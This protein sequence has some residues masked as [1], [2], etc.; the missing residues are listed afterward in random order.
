MA[1]KKGTVKVKS[2]NRVGDTPLDK[3]AYDVAGFK[4]KKVK[5]HNRKLP[6]KK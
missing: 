1:K 5:A 3:I 2:Y 6:K 4:S